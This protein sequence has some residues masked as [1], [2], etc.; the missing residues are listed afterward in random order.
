MVPDF[1]IW[2]LLTFFIPPMKIQWFGKAVNVTWDE[3]TRTTFLKKQARLE[4]DKARSLRKKDRSIWSGALQDL[5]SSFSYLAWFG[6]QDKMIQN[7]VW[8]PIFPE[9]EFTVWLIPLFKVS[10][11]SK[12]THLL[13]NLIIKTYFQS[14]YRSYGLKFSAL[15]VPWELWFPTRALPKPFPVVKPSVSSVSEALWLL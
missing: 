7:H 10:M 5:K 11:H 4:P 3:A 13:E 14:E 12:K 6:K 9:A 2:L 15:T 8:K 1:T